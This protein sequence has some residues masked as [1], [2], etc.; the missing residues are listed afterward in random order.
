LG[1]H[2]FDL[3]VANGVLE[4]VALQDLSASPSAV[5]L[6]FMHRLRELLAPGGRI[7][8]GIENRYGWAELR[9]ALDHSGL[10]YT[11]LMPRF[12]ARWAC[13]RSGSY[14]SHFN[15]GYRTYTYSHRG[16]TRLFE[17]VGLSIENTWVATGGYNQPSKLVP[18]DAAAI[19]FATRTRPRP[20]GAGAWMRQQAHAWM[21]R[22]WIWRWIGS[23]FAFLL[24][25]T[26]TEA[27]LTA[28][29]A[30][31]SSHA[32]RDVAQHA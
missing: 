28:P 27:R 4:W 13:A 10:P 25:P 11:S 12:L 6:V 22:K 8:L 26:T 5:Q 24:S 23:D 29:A 2:Q 31:T 32:A 14:R 18:L 17:Q 20:A 19:R 7:Y 16:Y 21:A 1:L 9:G 30:I 3:I 15:V